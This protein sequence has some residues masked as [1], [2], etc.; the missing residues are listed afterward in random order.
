MPTFPIY[1]KCNNRCLICSNHS[2]F[3][4]FKPE[5]IGGLI[6]R[7]KRF[8]QGKKE[9]LDDYKDAFSITGG[10]PTLYHSLPLLIKKIDDFFPGLR[11]TCLSNGRM[12]SYLDYAKQIM[13][14][15]VNL[16][17]V[18]PVHGHN[19]KLHDRITMV[20]GSFKQ[21][22][23]GIRNVL[24]LKKRNQFLE[25]RIVI[26]RLNY[27]FLGRIAEFIKKE[28]P[29]IER[30]VYIFF[31]IEGQAEKNL[32]RLKLTYTQLMP[33]INAVYDTVSFF[34]S[35]RF[36]H[37]PLCALPQKFFPYAWRTLP[38]FEVSF[39]ESCKK[40]NLKKWCLGVHKG[41]LKFIGNLEF[42]PVVDKITIKESGNWHHPIQEVKSS[43]G[44]P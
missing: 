26:H 10:E 17:L 43:R 15:D 23:E 13:Q 3:L 18:I 7:I 39:L 37:F 35:V 36:Y 32:K 38:E 29:Q 19:A 20:P 9:F 4:Q 25:I 28:F 11:I 27:K 34:P 33:Y 2:R 31:E 30:L 21:T 42:K 6:E 1:N 22:I 44:R 8:S 12:F 24:K 16:E 5:T 41:Y 14:L 40:C